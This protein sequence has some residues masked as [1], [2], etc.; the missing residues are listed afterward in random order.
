MVKVAGSDGL[1]AGAID[2]TGRFTGNR[3]TFCKQQTLRLFAGWGLDDL[4]QNPQIDAEMAMFYDLLVIGDDPEG[5]ERA[6]A[7][8]RLGQRIAVVCDLE[9]P[10]SVELLGKG[11]DLLV[12]TRPLVKEQGEKQ[13]GEGT[14]DVTMRGWRME[15]QRLSAQSSSTRDAQMRALGIEQLWGR[16]RFIAATTVEIADEDQNR[17]ASATKIVIACGT[18]SRQPASFQIDGRRV[19]VAESLLALNEM[20]R[21][22]LVVGAGTTG[23]AVA[24]ALARL[25]VEVTVVDEQLSLFDVSRMFDDS[26]EL[27]QSLQIAFR[28]G[29]EVIG[30][31]ASSRSSAAIRL[32]SGR[33]LRADAV[34]I[35]V[36]R[37]GNTPGLNLESAN[38]GLDERGRVWCDAAGQT[39]SPQIVA[40]GDVVG[41]PGRGQLIDHLISAQ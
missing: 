24:I 25:G 21:S 23:R 14:P 41:F 37:E 32:A 34:V 3:K 12:Q 30:T 22:A 5:L 18:V 31:E 38:V 33:I 11:A 40:V 28:L 9:K 15:V 27:F 2:M 16:A 36:G 13:T 10:P 7:A 29:E 17:I 6:T 20:P 4:T 1:D 8:S 26:L 19:V 39:W 35:C